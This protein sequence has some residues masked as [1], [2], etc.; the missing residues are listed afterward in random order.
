MVD[1]II[2]AGSCTSDN[3]TVGND[4][5]TSVTKVTIPPS[6][7]PNF[8][9]VVSDETNLAE[10]NASCISSLAENTMALSSTISDW[11]GMYTQLKLSH[12]IGTIPYRW[13][14]PNGKYF[15]TAHL[16]ATRCHVPLT[17]YVCSG[18]LF[19]NGKVTGTEK[20]AIIKQA[21][22]LPNQA[23]L[24]HSLGK[25]KKIL[26]IEENDGEWEFVFD[27]MHLNTLQPFLSSRILATFHRHKNPAL[28]ITASWHIGLCNSDGWNGT[29]DGGCR[30]D[31]LNGVIEACANCFGG[32]VHC[33]TWLRKEKIISSDNVTTP[34]TDEDQDQ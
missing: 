7:L 11:S 27:H 32:Y 6:K 31:D 34:K 33:P 8:L 25:Q 24:M 30:C 9:K 26:A 29:C 23:R 17:I 15:T 4:S 21:I 19:A 10:Y 22:G 2:Q 1:D 20:A 28:P 5:I 18:S 3:I 12:A 13:D 16:I 14:R